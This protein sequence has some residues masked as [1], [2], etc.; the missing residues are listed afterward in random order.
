VNLKPFIRLLL[1]IPDYYTTPARWN[2]SDPYLRFFSGGIDVTGYGSL[3]HVTGPPKFKPEN[4]VIVTDGYCASTCT[5]FA[6]F[7]TQQAGVKTIAMGGR[8]NKNPIQAIGGVKGVNN[9]AFSFIQQQ[10]QYAIRFDSSLNTSSF[11]TDYVSDVPFNRA[12]SS[13]V[14]NRD[15]LRRNDTSGLA[16]Q[17]VYDEA[18]CR[19]YYTPEMTVDI[20]AVWMAA[21]DAQWGNKGKCVSGASKKRDGHVT[22]KLRSGKRVLQMSLAAA[23]KEVQAFEDSFALETECNLKA[24]GFMQP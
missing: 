16:L 3:A 11:K 15:G 18:D 10:A 12:S 2:L 5:I 22:A 1:T 14:N 21:A 24:G 19:L 4:I 23:M 17:F 9:Y 7:L 8:S 13:G 6:E 20:T